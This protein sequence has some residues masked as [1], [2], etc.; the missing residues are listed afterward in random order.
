MAPGTDTA[1]GR[2][3][4]GV[5]SCLLG[6]RVRYDAGHKRLDVVAGVI[7]DHV[8]WVRVCPELEVGM[9][10]PRE[11][12][13]LLRGPGGPRMTGVESGRD[14]TS[15]MRAWAS[16]R[17]ASLGTLDGFVLKARSPSCGPRDVPV[18][19]SPAPGGGLWARHLASALPGLALADEDHL[20]DP[21]ARH[22]FLERVFG[23][24]RWH[25]F[26]SAE[27]RDGDLARFHDHH[28]LQI[29]AR[30][31]ERAADLRALAASAGSRASLDDLAGYGEVFT[32]ALADR[33][34][35]DSAAD[36]LRPLAPHS[37]PQ[38]LEAVSAYEAGDVGLD[39]VIL[40]V[41]GARGD[42]GS[43]PSVLHPY[44]LDLLDRLAGAG[45]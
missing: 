4:V 7:G 19:G 3:R 26:L 1:M 13:R 43:L 24:R 40:L 42:A 10:V 16:R 8:E 2:P 5:S 30:G 29:Q 28:H 34:L 44:P 25:A 45:G 17:L 35:P 21:E 11:P 38:L 6:D 31:P 9:G 37:R 18:A 27:R 20:Q 15:E 23:A 33:C 12:V 36:A 39:R 14:W 22:H 41:V 32:S